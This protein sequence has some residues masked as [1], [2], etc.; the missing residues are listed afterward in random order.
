ME[1]NNDSIDFLNKL[2]SFLSSIYSD[3]PEEIMNNI[4]FVTR[5]NC[6]NDQIIKKETLYGRFKN[7]ISNEFDEFNDKLM[8]FIYENKSNDAQKIIEKLIDLK[9]GF[10]EG[11]SFPSIKLDDIN[12]SNCSISIKGN[13]VIDFWATW[14]E[15]CQSPMQK[16]VDYSSKINNVR[17]IAISCDEKKDNWSSHINNKN[18]KSNVEH[19]NKK[20]I[21][22]ELGIKMLP[23]ICFIN[24][25]GIIEYFGHPNYI[26]FE[27]SINLYNKN[28]SILNDKEADENSF[29][30]KKDEDKKDI[31]NAIEKLFKEEKLNINCTISCTWNSTLNGKKKN[32]KDKV[33]LNGSIEECD[34]K[35]IES[36]KT[37]VV[38]MTGIIEINDKFEVRKFEISEDF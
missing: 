6:F 5:E 33:D 36:L 24:S 12:G 14:C 32:Y 35:K 38:K 22:D 37:K 9:I 17:F 10:G 23:A 1:V 25:K 15:F 19:Y 31:C 8:D 2:K 13:T 26:D 16:F 4:L 29:C 27:K 28:E 30:N 3:F 20:I 11:D 7:N 34:L 18:W 21:R